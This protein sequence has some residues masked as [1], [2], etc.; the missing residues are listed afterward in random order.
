MHAIR[1]KSRRRSTAQKMFSGISSFMSNGSQFSDLEDNS[2]AASPTFERK[3]SWSIVGDAAFQGSSSELAV[4]FLDGTQHSVR[5]TSQTKV[6]HIC[7]R[8]KEEVFLLYSLY[9]HQF[10]IL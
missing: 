10:D 2:V 4:Y 6:K 3:R 1:E 9:S 5:Y 7:L 8:I